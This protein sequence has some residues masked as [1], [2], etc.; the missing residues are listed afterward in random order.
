MILPIDYNFVKARHGLY[1]IVD[2]NDPDRNICL[3]TE[4]LKNNPNAKINVGSGFNVSCE[5]Q[6]LILDCPREDCEYEMTLVR[7]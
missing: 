2:A 5:N 7:G 1:R 3:V 6:E 4:T